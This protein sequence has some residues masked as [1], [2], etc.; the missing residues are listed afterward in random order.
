MMSDYV[1][2]DRRDAGHFNCPHHVAGGQI[3]SKA[4]DTHCWCQQRDL[5]SRDRPLL[6]R[7]G[8]HARGRAVAFVDTVCSV[9][10][11]GLH[12]QLPA[13]PSGDPDV[14]DLRDG[15]QGDQ[16]VRRQH[17]RRVSGYVR[18][19]ALHMGG[20]HL[21]LRSF[22]S[23]STLL[24]NRGGL[25]DDYLARHAGNERQNVRGD[26]TGVEEMIDSCFSFPEISIGVEL[27][28]TR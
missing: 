27:C 10:R 5:Q 21:G 16:H 28:L 13:V 19:Q 1:I 7:Q 25:H 12:V 3:W 22:A 18:N 26:S 4:S 17:D 6:L 8:V 24:C 23:F 9:H 14:G 15:D 20:D 11:I 2:N